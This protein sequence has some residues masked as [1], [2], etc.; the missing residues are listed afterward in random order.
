VHLA[1]LFDEEG[2]HRTGASSGAGLLR[3]LAHLRGDEFAAAETTA[4]AGK[5]AVQRAPAKTCALERDQHA[6]TKPGR[7][8]DL[9]ECARG[10]GGADR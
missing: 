10:G 7:L 5:A 1:P 3:A 9:G 2:S 6:G 4:L 8:L